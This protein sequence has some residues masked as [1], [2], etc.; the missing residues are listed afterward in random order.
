MTTNLDFNYDDFS[1]DIEQSIENDINNIKTIDDFSNLID[2]Y[3]SS[4]DDSFTL[5]YDD[6]DIDL[7]ESGIFKE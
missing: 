1:R 2:K 4:I 6:D 3:T 5:W 7:D